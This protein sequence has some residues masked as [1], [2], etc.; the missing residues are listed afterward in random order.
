MRGMM[1]SLFALTLF[2]SATPA[3]AQTVRVQLASSM[4]QAAYDGRVILIF[5]RDDASEPRFQVERGFQSAQIFGANVD[6][7]RGGQSVRFTPGITGY[8]LADLRAI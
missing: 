1:R 4:P 6:G 8:P 7:W 5:S 2:A 3:A